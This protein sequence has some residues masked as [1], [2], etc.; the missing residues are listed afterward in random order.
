M[1]QKE[2]CNGRVHGLERKRLA[3]ISMVME[4]DHK[5]SS[6]GRNGDEEGV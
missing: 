2:F 4:F 5:G 1:W 3:W 6:E